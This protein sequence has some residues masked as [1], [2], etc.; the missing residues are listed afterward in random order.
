[1]SDNL[2]KDTKRNMV[3]KLQECGLNN[4]TL[5]VMVSNNS[6]MLR[7]LSLNVDPTYKKKIPLIFN[8]FTIVILSCYIYVYVFSM[9]WFVFFKCIKTGDVISAMIVFALGIA[10]EITLVKWIYMF[11]NQNSLRNLIENYLIHD[12]KGNSNARLTNNLLKVLRQVKRRAIIFWFMIIGNGVAYAIKPLLMPGR[13]I[14]E[15]TEFLFG[16]EPLHESP[17]YE[18]AYLLSLGGV[19]FTCYGTSNLSGF[20]I[21]ITGYIEGQ[22]LCLSE[23]LVNI[24]DDAHKYYYQNHVFTENCHRVASDET[25]RGKDIILNE[26][27]RKQLRNI[28]DYHT[29]NMSFLRQIE[30]VFRNAIAIEFG[31]L[32]VSLIAEFLGGLE[33][34][35]LIMP[36]ALVQVTM[37]CITGQKLLDSSDIFHRAVY[38][39]NWENFDVKNMK[40]VLM[41]FRISHKGM[42]LSAGGLV[43]LSFLCL[44]SVARLIYS[45][46]TALRTAVDH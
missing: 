25:I 32:I 15:D 1:M 9:I 44:M 6:M 20:F 42:A 46:Y 8:I 27:V 10:S 38:E 2:D 11:L 34:T 36:F 31:L 28:I 41:M 29:T 5:P 14:M 33:N 3:I 23:E 43:K 39:C 24:W 12:V 4:C 18:I 19:I 30:D 45:T 17:N 37:D 21:I 16:L 7:G 26:Y 13:H 40:T 22:M 35:Y